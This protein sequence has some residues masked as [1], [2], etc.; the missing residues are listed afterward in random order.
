MFGFVADL[1]L[2]QVA[3][4]HGS[5]AAFLDLQLRIFGRG[6]SVGFLALLLSSCCLDA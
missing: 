2:D 5:F 4:T 3:W 6:G 1:V